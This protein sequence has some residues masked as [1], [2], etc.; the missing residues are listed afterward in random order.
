[1]YSFKKNSIC[2]KFENCMQIHD[3]KHICDIIEF[4]KTYL[5][6]FY[7]VIFQYSLEYLEEFSAKSYIS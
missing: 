7:M 4:D 1:M 2:F 6:I 5:Q 3:K